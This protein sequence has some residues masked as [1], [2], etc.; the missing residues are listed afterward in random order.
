MKTALIYDWL[1]VQGGGE[2]VLKSI[3]ESFSAK[4]FTLIKDEASLKGTY[5]E[6]VE[7]KTSF[8]QK[9]PYS[10]RQYRKY[11]PL[12]PLAIEQFDLGQYDLILSSS[13]CVA[14]GVMTHAEQLHVCYCFTPMRYAWDLYHQ[15]LDAT[16]LRRGIKGICAKTF[17]HY[18]RMW[19]LSSSHRVD[20][21]VGISKCI[22]RRIEKIYG[23][24]S[25]VIYPPVNTEFFSLYEKKENYY[26]TASR[27]VPYKKLD[28]IVDAFSKM[29]DKK[30]VVIGD[31]P[32]FA[33]VKSK[34]KSNTE[35][36]GY[37]NDDKLKD[38]LQRAKAFVFA[39]Y[40][41]FGIVPVEAQ[42][43][44]T[45][46]IAF[47]KGG[48]LE[49]VEENKTGI[50]FEEQNISSI[51]NAVKQFEATQD[52]FEPRLIHEHAQKFNTRRFKD[53]YKQF[54]LQKYEEYRANRYK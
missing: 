32:E 10:Q 16:K 25:V 50:F 36:V 49:T 18:L 12:F 6:D 20:E 47:G 19:D 42:A 21:Y 4:I 7:I 27:M 41:D 5:F 22:S 51:M 14:K 53:E 52:C 45:P 37:Q 2:K 9:L 38:Y 46:V 1:I 34:A 23:R 15:Y 48:I 17:L 11:L 39:A 8:I 24:K 54:V 26:V 3:C 44:G 43:C 13:H 31:G 30:L 40:E 28:L 35:L 29:P 33:K